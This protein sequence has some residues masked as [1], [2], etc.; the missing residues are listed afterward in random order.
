VEG[1]KGAAAEGKEG[2]GAAAMLDGEGLARVASSGVTVHGFQNRE[3][4]E[5][6]GMMAT[7]HKP[8]LWLRRGPHGARH[9]RWWRELAGVHETGSRD[10]DSPN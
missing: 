3:H 4:Q 9:G 6:A 1:K 8:F 7:S 5:R 2:R 10:H